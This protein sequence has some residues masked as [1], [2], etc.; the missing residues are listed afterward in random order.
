MK[1]I[2]ARGGVEFLAV[3]LGI[4]LSLWVDEYRENKN[5]E[6][7]NF[8]ILNRIYDNLEI[9]SLDAIWNYKAHKIKPAAA[10]RVI[11]WCKEGQPQSDSINLFISRLAIATIFTNND[12]EYNALKASGNMGL[13]KNDQLIKALYNY[14]SEV[15]YV[16]YIDE[17]IDKQ[18]IEQFIPFMS[19]YSNFYGY[20][21][22]YDVF[23][24]SF[25]SFSITKNP[26]EEK[27]RFYASMF[28]S[29][30]SSRAFVYK[31]LQGKIIELRNLIRQELRS[32]I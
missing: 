5:A 25:N 7:L 22:I 32:N 10:K 16:K 2:L 23:D 14:Y 30:S 20:S 1:N 6:E 17:T 29:Q 18:V 28:A 4:A 9:D 24:N 12:E 19:N 31:R 3:F 13:I 21:K 27:L 26:P 15:E 8:Q 11:S